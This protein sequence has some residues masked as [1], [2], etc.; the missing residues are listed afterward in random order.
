VPTVRGQAGLARVGRDH[1]QVFHV[2]DQATLS[3]SLTK[4]LG[5][6]RRRNQGEG[7]CV[8]D[9]AGFPFSTMQDLTISDAVGP[10]LMACGLAFRRQLVRHLLGHLRAHRMDSVANER[11][12]FVSRRQLVVLEVGPHQLVGRGGDHP[13]GHF[14]PPFEAAF[15]C[16]RARRCST[17]TAAC[18]T[19]PPRPNGV[20]VFV[21]LFR[22]M[23]ANELIGG[24]RKF[25][26]GLLALSVNDDATAPRI[27]LCRSGDK[28]GH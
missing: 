5:T 28:S 16:S 3:V 21:R 27:E 15:V 13:S 4:K 20:G 19:G 25:T 9:A 22:Q 12:R 18:R 26:D 2:A 23:T 11:G 24:R 17:R 6:V 7:R 1:L 14:V 8:Q 10:L